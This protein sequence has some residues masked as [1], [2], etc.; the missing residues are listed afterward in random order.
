MI[1]LHD[2]RLL[3]IQMHYIWKRFVNVIFVRQYEQNSFRGN[4]TTSVLNSTAFELST[5]PYPLPIGQV[6]VTKR[7]DFWRNGR[8]RHGIKLN[9]E[10]T[11]DLEGNSKSMKE[12]Q[13]FILL[14]PSLLHAPNSGQRMRVCVLKHTPGVFSVFQNQNETVYSGLEIEVFHAL[15]KFMTNQ[16]SN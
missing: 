10:K 7:L 8:Y 15:F 1:V 5:V 16:R 13:S 11:D 6:F 14:K 2:Y 12:A 4:R 3:Q 9:V